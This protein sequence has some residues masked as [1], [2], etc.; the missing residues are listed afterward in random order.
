MAVKPI[1]D[2][3]HAITPYL[4]ARDAQKLLDFLKKAFNA[5]TTFEPMMRPDGAIMHAELKIGDSRVM[6]TEANEQMPPTQNSLHLYV[7]DVDATYKRAVAAGGASTMEPMDM[8]YG[9][10]AAA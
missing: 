7:P 6:L 2:G 9:T 4:A 10:A 8:F 5:E 1:P 3:Y